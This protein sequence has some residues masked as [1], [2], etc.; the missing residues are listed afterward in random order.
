MQHA[1]RRLSDYGRAVPQETWDRQYREG[2]WEFLGSIGE[3]A[4]YMV[5]AGYVHY[6][7]KSPTILDLGCGQGRL[8]E[9]LAAFPFK[10]Y[11][12]IDLSSE[13]IQ[14][15]D[16]RRRKNARFR[17]A[18]F[19]TWT[20][21][22]RSSVIVFCE[23]LNYATHPVSALLRYA[24][25]LEENGAIIVSLYQHPNHGKIW[26]SADKHFTSVDSTSVTNH[27]GKTWDIKVFQQRPNGTK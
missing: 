15:A 11:L 26:K 22:Q 16:L 17:V 27:K 10:S 6:L 5:I 21:P 12:G 25:A 20:P 4:H 23:S 19:D 2:A 9:Y 24:G 3:L 1:A 14:Q 8:L 13:A 18:D 7:F